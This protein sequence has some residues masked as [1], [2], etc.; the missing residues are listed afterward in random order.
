MPLIEFGYFAGLPERAPRIR[1]SLRQLGIGA[2]WAE[3]LTAEP[4]LLEAV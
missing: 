3:L 1:K 4:Q 2:T